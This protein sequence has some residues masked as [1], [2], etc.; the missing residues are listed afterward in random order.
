MTEKEITKLKNCQEILSFT[1]K[2]LSEEVDRIESQMAEYITLEKQLTEVDINTVSRIETFL[3]NYLYKIAEKSPIE[4]EKKIAAVMLIL[5]NKLSFEISER[6]TKYYDYSYETLINKKKLEYEAL[7]SII[8][9]RKFQEL[10]ANFFDHHP[11]LS[12][13]NKIK[14]LSTIRFY[15]STSKPVTSSLSLLP[16]LKM[17]C[18]Q[19]STQERSFTI[20]SLMGLISYQHLAFND[21]LLLDGKRAIGLLQ[22]DYREKLIITCIN[23]ATDGMVSLFIN[24]L[25]Q[26]LVENNIEHVIHRCNL[27]LVL[28]S[29]FELDI[30]LLY[31]REKIVSDEITENYEN[32]INKLIVFIDKEFNANSPT[33]VVTGSDQLRIFIQMY[34]SSIQRWIHNQLPTSLRLV[35]SD[36]NKGLLFLP[37]HLKKISKNIFEFNNRGGF[38]FLSTN[39][40][41]LINNFLPALIKSLKQHKTESFTSDLQDRDQISEFISMLKQIKK[42]ASCHIRQLEEKI[43]SDEIDRIAFAKTNCLTKLLNSLPGGGGKATAKDIPKLLKLCLAY[44]SI[45]PEDPI[46]FKSKLKACLVA[47]GAEIPELKKDLNLLISY[48]GND[49]LYF[50]NMKPVVVVVELLILLLD[51]SQLHQQEMNLCGIAS[52]L[53]TVLHSNPT[54]FIDMA[55]N[56]A[57]QGFVKGTKIVPHP[58]SMLKDKTIISALLAAIKHSYNK[59]GYSQHSL[60]MFEPLRGATRPKQIVNILEDLGFKNIAEQTVITSLNGKELPEWYMNILGKVYSKHHKTYDDILENILA[61]E[62]LMQKNKFAIILIT[63]ELFFQIAALKINEISNSLKYLNIENSH[64]VF[65]KDITVCEYTVNVEIETYGHSYSNALSHSEFLKGYRGAI[66]C[67]KTFKPDLT[68]SCAL[69]NSLQAYGPNS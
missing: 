39:L 41:H 9:N 28:L 61:L 16:N 66:T 29:S 5:E 51:P 33:P 46:Q 26:A 59:T 57:K 44:I 54:F 14:T 22:I 11:S 43:Y 63:Q 8:K 20:K 34:A 35:I 60:S 23:P 64:Y 32:Y 65:L 47:L 6:G 17:A 67:D 62:D 2:D 13:F 52:I 21:F 1:D 68:V 42:D 15:L 36:D 10:K 25:S 50:K 56:F 37:K 40:P 69:D 38:H 58:D 27:H 55:L 3:D 18:Y 49:T 4:L 48:L 53:S 31:L 19:I 45:K 7:R 30:L 24:Q 12:L